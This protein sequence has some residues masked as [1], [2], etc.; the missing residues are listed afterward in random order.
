MTFVSSL[1]LAFVVEDCARTT[2]E[3]FDE[4]QTLSSSLS[5]PSPRLLEAVFDGF[6]RVMSRLCLFIGGDCC[7]ERVDGRGVD[8]DDVTLFGRG[9]WNRETQVI[10]S[11]C[12]EWEE[13][14]K[15]EVTG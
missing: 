10:P 5:L 4:E 15:K 6:L 13:R 8:R 12:P 9:I 11:R 7:C 3:D 14:K 2:S 1:G